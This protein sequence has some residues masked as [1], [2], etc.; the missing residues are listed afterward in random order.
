MNRS[1]ITVV[2]LACT[3]GRIPFWDTQKKSWSD[4]GYEFICLDCGQYDVQLE[5][6]FHV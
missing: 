3:E 5:E 4:G 2:R 1:A 6:E